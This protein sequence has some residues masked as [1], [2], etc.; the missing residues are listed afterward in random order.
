MRK[1]ILARTLGATW[2]RTHAAVF[3][4]NDDG[5]FH[6]YFGARDGGKSRFDPG[7]FP[8]SPAPLLWA[9]LDEAASIDEKAWGRLGNNAC[10]SR[11]GNELS[12]GFVMGWKEPGQATPKA[13]H[14]KPLTPEE[15]LSD[16]KNLFDKGQK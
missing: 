7:L 1:T 11:C 6:A 15:I 13:D 4:I 10:W 14:W 5:R 2:P 12:V 16:I 3:P 9:W 8:S